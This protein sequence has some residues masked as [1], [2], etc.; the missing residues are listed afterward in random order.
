MSH[1][2]AETKDP[3]GHVEVS[4]YGGQTP[5]EVATAEVYHDGTI[6]LDVG[7]KSTEE[8]GLPS[9]KLARDG[10]VSL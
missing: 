10:H 8:G 1:E 3:V 5:A 6:L 4:P 2:M 9:L 7:V